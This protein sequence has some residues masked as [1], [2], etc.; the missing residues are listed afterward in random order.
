MFLR[1]N[2][3]AAYFFFIV[4]TALGVAAR[5]A[6]QATFLIDERLLAAM[7]AFLSAC[8]GALRHVFLQGAHHTVFPCVDVVGVE[9]ESVYEFQHLVDGH[10]VA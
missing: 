1:W 10:A 8:L 2:M 3:A 9:L 7:W 6:Y 4:S 5:S